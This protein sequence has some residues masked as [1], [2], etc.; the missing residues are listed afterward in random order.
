MGVTQF[1]LNFIILNK[2]LK[3]GIRK[4]N[5]KREIKFAI[6]DSKIFTFNIKLFL[7]SPNFQV[8]AFYC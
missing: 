8:F 3:T 1:C 5:C 7:F 6:R 2:D 4:C